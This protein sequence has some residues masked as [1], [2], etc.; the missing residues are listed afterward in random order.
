MFWGRAVLLHMLRVLVS[1]VIVD[2]HAQAI[3][4]WALAADGLQALD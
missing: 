3:A 2:R 4:A 1:L